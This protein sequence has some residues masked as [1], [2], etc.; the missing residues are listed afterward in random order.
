MNVVVFQHI[1]NVVHKFIDVRYQIASRLDSTP[2]TELKLDDIIRLV[3]D[4]KNCFQATVFNVVY[5][6]DSILIYLG[7]MHIN[8]IPISLLVYTFFYAE[9]VQA[10]F[11]IK[12]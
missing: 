2:Q 10:A 7:Q 1:P 4:P 9:Y 6:L 12:A 11:R 3:N 5:Y 8:I